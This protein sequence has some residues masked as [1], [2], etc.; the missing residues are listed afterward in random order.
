MVRCGGSRRGDRFVR[1]GRC[2]SPAIV[3]VLATVT[4]LC[5][6]LS[7]GTRTWIR[8][9][10]LRYLFALHFVRFVGIAFLVLVSRGVLAREFV[11]IGWGDTI[12]AV[13]AV[14]LFVSRPR[15]SAPV[16]W[17]CVLVWN[18]IGFGDMLMLIVTGV[19]LGSVAP[20]TFAL[21]LQLPFGLLPTF[22]VPLIIA[23][24]VF[25]FIRLFAH[26]SAQSPL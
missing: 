17:W 13:G 22:F 21:F 18:C 25:I 14:A 11:P 15:L 20:E 3:V 24:H 1:A 9:V 4:I 6:V 8:T 12:A 16:G 2:S 26:R 5:G 23:S 7:R 10:D 19:R